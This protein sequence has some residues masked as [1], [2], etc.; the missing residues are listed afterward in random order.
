MLYRQCIIAAA[1]I[2]RPFCNVQ[3]Q[4]TLMDFCRSASAA[5]VESN[6]YLFNV[7]FHKFHTSLIFLIL[8]QSS[9]MNDDMAGRS[10]EPW[11]SQQASDSGYPDNSYNN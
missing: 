11:N 4:I 5:A 9:E 8:T 10:G 1:V 2:E 7:A 6:M 3:V